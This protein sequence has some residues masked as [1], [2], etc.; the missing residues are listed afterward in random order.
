MRTSFK[1]K[2]ADYKKVIA[3]AD[4][5]VE[6]EF[7]RGGAHGYVDRGALPFEQVRTWLLP[8]EEEGEYYVHYSDKRMP[9]GDF[10]A[11]HISND[12]RERGSS[13]S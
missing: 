8:P 4:V 10:G 5:R 11:L 7:R 3:Q 6:G 13:I 12:V 9:L 1:I 2:A